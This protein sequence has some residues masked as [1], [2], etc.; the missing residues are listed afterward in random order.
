MQQLFPITQLCEYMWAHLASTLIGDAG[1]QTFHMYIGHGQNGKSVLM[2]L[3]GMVLGN[4]KGDVPLSV[5]TDRRT[6]VGGLSP[7]LVMLKGVR[8]AVINEPQKEDRINEGM[9]KQLT[10]GMDPIQAR[11][12]YMTT[13]LTYVP[14][15][16]LA[17][18][19]NAF[20]EIRAQD[21]G[22]WRRIR[23]VD[24]MS[25]FTDEPV[26][27]DP[28]KPYQFKL[29]TKVKD[30]KVPLWKEVFAA[31]LVEKAFQTGGK[32]P[33]CDIVKA[34]SQSYR[35]RQDVIAEFIAEKIVEDKTSII[36][37]QELKLV[38]SNWY[39]NT[40]GKGG[41]KQKDVHEYMD[42]TFAKC[43]IRKV[44]TGVRIRYETDYIQDAEEQPVDEKDIVHVSVEDF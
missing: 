5:L 4:Y 20:M 30:E 18:C 2:D 16:K 29:D 40:Y 44:W 15:F 35:Q 24:F 42:K 27:N 41:P 10:S 43:A 3:M 11:A 17:L 32:L 12:P 33:S 26:A 39:E 13:V 31:L 38:F 25:L 1:D 9:M 6:K 22:T 14:Q 7:E 23:V 8:Y 21:H 36:T 34:S 19:S 28:N 37:K